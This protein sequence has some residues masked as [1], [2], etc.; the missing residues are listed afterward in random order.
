MAP[1]H[2]LPRLRLA[3]PWS[4][5]LR[6]PRWCLR[7][8][9]RRLSLPLHSCPPAKTRL[10]V[11]LLRLLR[12]LDSHI[13]RR[14]IIYI[15]ISIH[16]KRCVTAAATPTCLRWKRQGRSHRPGGRDP[17][18]ATVPQRAA[19]RLHPAPFLAVHGAEV[20][21]LLLWY[22]P[23]RVPRGFTQLIRARLLARGS[24]PSVTRAKLAKLRGARYKKR[25][26]RT[27]SR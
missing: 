14:S 13:Q 1:Y 24:L 6:G 18:P 4:L 25:A 12:A 3:T 19:S 16:R 15:Y 7:R 2:C 8:R 27:H 20:D 26:A 5:P 10:R 9:R 23:T 21:P 22:P 17:V 11:F